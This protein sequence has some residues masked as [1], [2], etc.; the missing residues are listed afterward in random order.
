MLS[1]SVFWRAVRKRP[2]WLLLPAFESGW[3]RCMEDARYLK[4]Q[5]WAFSGKRLCLDPPGTFN[6]KIA[7]LKMNDHREIYRTLAD[8]CHARQFVQAHLDGGWLVPLLGVW[9]KVEDIDI[10]ALPERFVLKCTHGY[11]GTVL[12]RDKSALDVAS[13]RAVL[14]KTLDTDFY[15][16]GREWAYHSPTPRVMAEAL[17]DDGGGARPAD[18]KFMCFQG[19]TEFVCIS[20]GLGDFSTGAVSFFYPEGRPA[21]F[22]RV[23]YPQCPPAEGLPDHFGRMKAAAEALA[24]AAGV[25]FVR[26]DFY[27][28]DGRP[29]FSEFTFYPCGG[30]LFFDPPQYDRIL[31]ELL[32]LP[33]P[34]NE[35]S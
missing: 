8:K 25:P 19:K 35:R 29:Y 14:Q 12:C 6:E 17:I 32:T 20:R 3:L 1:K 7:W 31:G 2:A 11:G 34:K 9:D 15:S 4:L 22:K 33:G 26:V 28:A 5:Y 21:P 24:A 18:Y 23:D 13:V 27:E 10:S 30:S 16:R